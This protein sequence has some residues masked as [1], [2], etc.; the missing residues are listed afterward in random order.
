MPDIDVTDLL[1]DPDFCETVTLIRR[2]QTIDNN[3]VAS[4]VETSS[5][6]TAVVTAMD[7]DMVRQPEGEY[8]KNSIVVHSITRLRGVTPGAVPDII[9]WH[10]NNYIVKRSNDWSDFGAGFTS[11]T[12]TL[13]DTTAQE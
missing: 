7:G 8:A 3:G 13:T 4:N 5:Q 9:V 12:C 1:V 2:S 11:A 6:I 10:G